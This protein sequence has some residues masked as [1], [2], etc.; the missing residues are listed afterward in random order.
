MATARIQRNN[1][2]VSVVQM[3]NMRNQRR[4][5]RKPNEFFN[6]KTKPFDIAPFMVHPVLPGETLDN[7][8]FQARIV[9]DPIKN[10]L[11]GWWKEYY[12]YYVPLP[13]LTNWDTTGLLQSMM[14]DPTTNLTSLRAAAN[15]VPYYTFNG[16]VD[17][18]KNCYNRIILHH[19]RDEDENVTTPVLQNYSCA[20][21]DQERWFHSLKTAAAGAD[22]ME[23]PG[24]DEREELDILPGFSTQYAQWE[25]MRDT[26]HTDLAYEDYIR[27]Y[28][29]QI[30]DGAVSPAGNAKQLDKF[31]PELIRFFRKWTYPTNTVEP[32]TGTPASAC[33]WSIAEKADKKRF[34][35]YPGFIMGV[36]VTRPKIYLG[37]QKGHPVGILDNAY[38][39]LPAVLQGLE[40]TS[41]DE[42]T[43]SATTGILQNQS[44][45]YWLDVQDVF[46]YGSQFV[47]H[48]MDAAANHG[49]ALPTAA[50]DKKY[51]T[52]AMID[53]LFKTV[54][55]EFIREDGVVFLDILGRMG[56]DQTQ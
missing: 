1:P 13:G 45:N 30:E 32:T 31:E 19:F 49:I 18:I 27:S 26:G 7:M 20:Q 33:S 12:F 29:V 56:P 16:G 44:T 23:L 25:L 17:Y 8:L 4:T 40:Y 14:L 43:F 41:V 5:H 21:I 36:T 50:M 55:S 34:F 15:D 38:T 48:A 3:D 6:L 24:V 46:R 52:M 35:K 2:S 47:N 37:S 42:T 39:W 10:P 53:S 54:G 22:D 28:G 51:P 9:S 11:I